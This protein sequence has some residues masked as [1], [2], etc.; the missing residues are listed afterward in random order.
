MK[1]IL[2]FML[3]F[4]SSSLV[5]ASGWEI[6]TINDD[7]DV[8]TINSDKIKRVDT[9]LP[10]TGTV[11]SAWVRTTYKNTDDGIVSKL[12]EF[13]IKCKQDEVIKNSSYL[14]EED[15][16]VAHSVVNKVTSV[17]FAKFQP[18]IPDSYGEQ[19]VKDICSYSNIK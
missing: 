1:N 18:V 8:H 15:G 10:S 12:D 19:W 4:A 17:D 5:L 7:G 2:I 16:T 9:R 13:Y 11:I 14:Y 6:S 3:L